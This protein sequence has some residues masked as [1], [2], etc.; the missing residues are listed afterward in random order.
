MKTA[1]SLP[2]GEWLPAREG[3]R[4][5]WCEGGDPAGVPVLLVHGGPGGAS[6]PDPPRWLA[7][8]P[9]RWIAID[10]R[11]CGRS[12]PPGEIA[13]ND[14]AALVADMEALRERLGLDRWSLLAGS[15]GA[16]VALAYAGLAPGRLHGLFLRSPFL[17]SAAETR[18]YIA[19]WPAW[20]GA[21]GAEWLGDAAAEAVRRLF[22]AATPAVSAEDNGLLAADRIVA[23]WSAYDD[24]QSLPGGVFASGARCDP[25]ALPAPSPATLASWRIHRH[26]AATGWGG[27]PPVDAPLP[28]PAGPLAIAWGAADAC[29]DPAVARRLAAAWPAAVACE[30]AGGGHRMGEARIA[31]ALALAAR[32]WAVRL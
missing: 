29:C 11:G 19:G 27:P 21:A 15:W 17:G 20:L 7:G 31:P 14:L 9:L 18:R 2:A 6:R 10:Q 30:V 23:A 1:E 25:A 4:V 22:E 32:A 13:A 5:W 8:L 16:R 28:H 26:Y 12:T 3:H 24:A